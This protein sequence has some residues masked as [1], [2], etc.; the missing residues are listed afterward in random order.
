[1]S[2][3]NSIAAALASLW[4]RNLPVLLARLDLLTKAA[5]ADPLPDELRL[6]AVG[7]AHKLAGSLGM[8]GYNEATT[9][10]RSLEHTLEHEHPDRERVLKLLTA[11]RRQLPV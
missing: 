9:I 3:A 1:M 8:F 2:D 6:E 7:V 5:A 4:E 10:A 11:L